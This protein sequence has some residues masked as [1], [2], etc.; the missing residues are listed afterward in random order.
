MSE[1]F[2]IV[3]KRREIFVRNKKTLFNMSRRNQKNNE[4]SSFGIQTI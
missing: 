4:N 1:Y 2:K 3:H